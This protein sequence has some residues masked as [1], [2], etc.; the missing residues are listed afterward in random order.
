MKLRNGELIWNPEVALLLTVIPKGRQAPKTMDEFLALQEM[1]VVRLVAEER[2]SGDLRLAE[3]TL[4]ELPDEVAVALPLEP[5]FSNP[6]L[7]GILV[8]AIS[9]IQTGCVMEAIAEG[10]KPGRTPEMMDAVEGL[11]LMGWIQ[12]ML[13]P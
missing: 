7:P 13:T 1:M 8:G 5:K 2:A 11:D 10:S 9:P 6:N 12:R 3:I 4:E